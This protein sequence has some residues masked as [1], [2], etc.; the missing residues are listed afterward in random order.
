M[1]HPL[2]Q[3]LKGL[4][5]AG[6]VEDPDKA[7]AQIV[8]TLTDAAQLEELEPE[9][10]K[11]K[12]YKASTEAEAEASAVAATLRNYFGDDEAHKDA[13]VA[14]YKSVGRE[15]FL[16]KYPAVGDDAPALGGSIAA[17][18]NTGA[19]RSTQ[20]EPAEPIAP[21]AK[22]ALSRKEKAPEGNVVDI[23]LYPGANDSERAIAA[24]KATVEGADKWDYDTLC[25]TA[26][27]A[28]REGRFVNLSKH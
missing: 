7:A 3:K 24:L 9:F 1:K 10:K 23:S 5:T 21:K 6:G 14:L 16:E 19:R 2:I 20:Q 15:K 13:V 11:L 12:S 4:M 17:E 25:A 22:V 28:R 26:F 18:S 27:N 8:K